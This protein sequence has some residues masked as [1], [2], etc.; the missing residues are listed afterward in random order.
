M[1]ATPDS[2]GP[3]PRKLDYR[4]PSQHVPAGTGTFGMILFLIALFMLFAAAMLGYVLIRL[5]GSKS[6]APGTIQ[7]PQSFWL[8]T[9][10]VVAASVTIHLSEKNL[11]RERL[12]S[13]RRWLITT[14]ALA[15][16]FVLVQAPSMVLL[17]HQHHTGMIQNMPLYGFIFFL[18]LIHALHVVGGIVALAI[19]NA[20][21][22]QGRY[23]HEH[24]LP[25]HHAAMYW[26][27]LDGVWLT[28][29]IT[30]LA[31]G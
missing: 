2:G 20:K 10:L 15:I 19:T 4:A 14:L 28:M 30:F 18:V 16:G 11:R 8:S 21:A 9:A 6:P 27:F 22:A 1:P 25:V 24:Y 7:I 26:H 31:L 17:L 3:G 12:T 13:F 23:D 29:F 5:H